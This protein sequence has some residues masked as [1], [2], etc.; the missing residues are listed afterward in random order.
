MST[1]K[2]I[3]T[4][5]ELTGILRKRQINKFDVNMGVSG[6]RGNG[7]TLIKGSKV[8]MANGDWKNCEDIK[9]GDKVISPQINESFSVSTVISTHS[10]FESN[11]YELREEA[12]NK[13]LLYSCSYNHLIPI[14]KQYSERTSKDDSTRRHYERRLFNIS[15]EKLYKRK[16]KGSHV[17]SFTTSAIDF[18]NK[19]CSLDSYSL[20]VW[21][22]DGSFTKKCSL[23][24]TSNDK[25]IIDNIPYNISRINN[26]KN[27]TCKSYHY[28]LLGEFAKKLTE[29]GLKNR[30]SKNK[31]I[32]K[33]A[34]LSSIDYR[35]NLLAGLIDTDGFI[36]KDNQI[37]YCTKSELLA[38]DLKDLVFSLGGYSVIRTI[39]KKCQNGIIG[40]YFDVSIQFKDPRIIPLKLK[41][42][43]DRLRLRKI[44]PR[45]IAINIIKG[46]PNYVYGFELDKK[47]SPSQ[48]FITDNWMITHNST[49]ISKIFNSFKKEGFNQRK[50]QVYAR[51]DV[52]NL[53]ACQQ[54]GYCWDDEAINS[55][56]KRDFQNK[57]QK[58]LIKIITNYRDNHNIYASALPFFYSLD[59]DLRDLIFLHLHVIERGVAVLFLPLSD[60][61]HT[62]DQWDTKNNIK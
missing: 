51:K 19:D 37:T 55:G 30:T 12:R 41:K 42:K 31:F 4:I 27:T 49:I 46:K 13:R 15:A 36:S 56:Y 50:H 35:F 34:M 40:D 20:G 29:L 26:K 48:W 32:P 54:F 1:N 5:R 58:D 16:F 43:Y 3:W 14:I 61:I 8:L 7:K 6:K 45:N 10:R 22:G 23:L 38:N 52:I 2:V 24:I 44:N 18:G 60:Q 28:S 62:Q 39:K 59:K 17:C 9:L 11:I 47:E 21:L 25:V 33:V 57:G 53:L